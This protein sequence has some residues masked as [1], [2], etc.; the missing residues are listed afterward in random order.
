MTT[1]SSRTASAEHNLPAPLTSLLGRARELAGIGEGLRRTRLVTV[2]GPGGVGKTRL[3]VELARGQIRRRADGVWLVDLTTGPEVPDVAHETARA[4]G[5]RSTSGEK[6]TAALQGYLASRDVLLVLDNCEHVIDL[7]AELANA[8]LTTCPGVRILATSREPLGVDGET[9]WS[10]DALEPEDA[11]RLFVER[12]RQRRPDFMPGV[13]DEPTITELCERVDR[14]PLAIELAAARVGAMSPAEIVA[15][16]ESEL[17]ELGGHR[18][19]SPPRPP[20]A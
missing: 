15:G 19:D 10:L 12:A 3:A 11:F 4:L 5:L 1:G 14:L 16:L 17:G 9:V 20:P 7:S 8:V 13:D 6:A 2:T 18:R